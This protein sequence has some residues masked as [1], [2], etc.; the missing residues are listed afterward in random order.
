MARPQWITKRGIWLTIGF[1][2]LSGVVSAAVSFAITYHVFGSTE[3]EPAAGIFWVV[4]SCLLFIA[5]LFFGLVYLIEFLHTHAQGGSKV[6]WRNYCLRLLLSLTALVGPVWMFNAHPT[7]AQRPMLLHVLNVLI[8]ALS[9]ALL[10]WAFSIRWSI[11]LHG[12]TGESDATGRAP[13]ESRS[14]GK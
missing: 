6:R 2:V 5:F 10:L 8:A 3:P 7:L 1:V 14:K 4:V 11:P 12:K 13:E 9:V